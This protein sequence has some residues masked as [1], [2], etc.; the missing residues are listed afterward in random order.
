[1]GIF[2][3]IDTFFF[4]SLGITFVF[5]LLLIYHFKQQIKALE[6]KNDT[7][8]E[9]INNIV[10][11]ISN[12]RA[13]IVTTQSSF[14]TSHT[15]IPEVTREIISLEREIPKIFVSDESDDE[16]EESDIDEHDDED[17]TD[18]ED[19]D[20]EDGDEEEEPHEYAEIILK[21]ELHEIVNSEN[22]KII[23][24]DIDESQAV[25]NIDNGMSEIIHVEKMENSEESTVHL[26]LNENHMEIYKKMNL[27]ALKS[28]VISKGL[29]SDPS[30]LKKF[31][32]LKL[33]EEQEE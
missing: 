2:N 15:P 23:T 32:I 9:I 10:K 25:N 1:M 3:Y 6:Q 12:V 11:E 7:M 5:I 24:V 30:K 33:L 20:G 26:T 28:L 19:S 27:T 13:L 14:P 18:S 21:K 4:I 8:F 31:E 16:E 29:S 22:I 17:V